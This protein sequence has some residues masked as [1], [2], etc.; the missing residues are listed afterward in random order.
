MGG[1]EPDSTGSRTDRYAC[2]GPLN[3][4]PRRVAIAT[5]LIVTFRPP[6]VTSMRWACAHPLVSGFVGT[7]GVLAAF[8]LGH[9]QESEIGGAGHPVR[10]IAAGAADDVDAVPTIKEPRSA[11]KVRE[12]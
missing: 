12:D 2:A 1:L 3:A 8:G 5:R 10:L 11:H 6:A 9:R 7:T 4:A